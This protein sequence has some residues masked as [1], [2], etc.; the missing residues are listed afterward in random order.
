MKLV[1]GLIASLITMSSFAAPNFSIQ[2]EVQPVV[3]VANSQNTYWSDNAKSMLAVDWTTNG[4]ERFLFTNNYQSS[5][6][7][8][9]CAFRYNGTSGLFGFVQKFEDKAL[10]LNIELALKHVMRVSHCDVVLT[11]DTDK[12]ELTDVQSTCDFRASLES[13]SII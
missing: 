9:G 1:T 11:F 7:K 10:C 2:N 3:V 8:E 13:N 6:N 5:G 4:E 12:E